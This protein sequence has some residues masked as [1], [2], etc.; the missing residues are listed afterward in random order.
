MKLD[1]NSFDSVLFDLVLCVAL[2]G[3]FWTEMWLPFIVL[4]FIR[5]YEK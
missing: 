1:F 4:L 5:I 3:G 2:F